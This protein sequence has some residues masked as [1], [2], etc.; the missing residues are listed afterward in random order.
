M[1]VALLKYGYLHLTW[2]RILHMY[3]KTIVSVFIIPRNN[4]GNMER[5]AFTAIS[6]HGHMNGFFIMRYGRLLGFGNIQKLIMDHCQNHDIAV[7][8]CIRRDRASL[9]W[10]KLRM[11]AD[12]SKIT[13]LNNY[14]WRKKLLQQKW[15]SK[16]QLL[17]VMD[18]QVSAQKA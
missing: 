13:K 17:C 8:Y 14:V 12:S 11:V 18:V 10:N 5:A 2:Y 7:D 1:D 4:L 3:I 9:K 16:H 15:Q 6:F